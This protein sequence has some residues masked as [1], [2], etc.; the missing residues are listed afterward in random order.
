MPYITGKKEGSPHQSLYWRKLEQ[1]AIRSGKW[2]LI[3]AQGLAPML[4][5]LSEDGSELNDLAKANPEVVKELLQK[6]KSW[7]SELVTPLWQEG[8]GYI[9]KRKAW[10]EK[11]RDRKEIPQTLGKK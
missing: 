3:R 7:E 8:K 6:L 2:K 1:A 9:K 5:N 4:Y 11:F 10:N